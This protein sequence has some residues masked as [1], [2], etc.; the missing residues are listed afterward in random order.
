[1]APSP[2][3]DKTCFGRRPLM[4]E[5][6]ERSLREDLMTIQI[7]LVEDQLAA[8]EAV[9]DL[10]SKEGGIEVVGEASTGREA[11]RLTADLQPDVVVM[12]LSLPGWNGIETT[13]RIL[14]AVPEI[15]VVG[16]SMY[17]DPRLQEEMARA[18]AAAFVLKDLAFEEL[19]G[20]VRRVA[21]HPGA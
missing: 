7:L 2:V 20:T 3:I 12:D 10:L 8:R 17:S 5:D 18:G 13:R 15:R 19:A 1:M 21:A 14:S 9:R 11:L 6:E 16:L 4:V